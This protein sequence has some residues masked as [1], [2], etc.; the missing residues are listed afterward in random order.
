M[1]ATYLLLAT[2]SAASIDATVPST[3]T[4]SLQT[5]LLVIMAAAL[6]LVAWSLAKLRTRIDDLEH[7]QKNSA[8]LAPPAG[9]GRAAS[10]TTNGAG[11]PSEIS[12]TVPDEIAAVIAAAIHA[13]FGSRARVAAVSPAQHEDRVWSLEGRR[14]IFHSHKI[15]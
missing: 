8:P 4:V 9:A 12:G 7:A 15:R 14:Q 3:G 6:I 2:Q 5:A 10:M 11:L 13:T 1:N